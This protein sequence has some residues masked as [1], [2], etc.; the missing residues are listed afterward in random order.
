MAA[1]RI[2]STVAAA[3]FA[4]TWMHSGSAHAEQRPIRVGFPIVLSGSG[5]LIGHPM[6]RGAEMFVREVNDRGG[7]LGRRLELI[8]R[9]TRGT[10]EDA[11]RVARDFVTRDGMDFLVGG[12]RAG[13]VAAIAAVS[14]EYKA[15]YI[16]PAKA[17]LA[18]EPGRPQPYVFRS[19][20][21]SVIEGRIAAGETAKLPVMKVYSISP[22]DDYGHAVTRGFV[23]WLRRLK[24]GVQ[25]VGQG[26]PKPADLDY[27]PFI[28]T[29]LAAKPD[30]LFT[31]L[32]GGQFTAFARHGR[33]V[34]LFERLKVVATGEAGAPEIGMALRDELPLGIVTNAY[35]LFYAHPVPEHQEY[36]ERLKAF[37][38]QEYP[39]SWA[40]AG[41]IAMQFLA[42]AI[43]RAGSA[44]AER[45]ARALPGLTIDSPVGR[46]TMRSKDHQATRGQFWGV[47]ARSAD[48]PFPILDPVRYVAADDLLD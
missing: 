33:S 22:D 43:Q 3:V 24:P 25:L 19:G 16:I 13:E 38:S 9:D 12:L 7:V 37:A 18:S 44:D 11:A 47:T 20:T 8:A 2:W 6:L 21:S 40:S 29:A 42:E 41:Y 36:V 32:W 30:A 5:A 17:T 26:W 1:G 46:L 34:A 48:Y 45:V 23:D 10:A 31:A 14:R 15:L 28:A 4:V 27:P 35:D 39:S